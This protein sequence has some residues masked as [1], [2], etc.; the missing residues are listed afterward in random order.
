[1]TTLGGQHV[2]LAASFPSGERGQHYEP[3]DAGAIADAVTA[4]VR[5]VLANDGKMLFGGHPTITPLVLLV[6]RELRCNNAVEVFQSAWFEDQITQETRAL[7]AAGHGTIRWTARCATREESLRAMRA[8]M[9]SDAYTPAAAVFVGGMEGIEDE[10]RQVTESWPGTPR[11][12]LPGPGGAAARLPLDGA[13]S[14]LGDTVAS[15]RYPYVAAT[16]VAALSDRR[17]A[18][19]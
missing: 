19:K 4:V 10:Y 18:L 3:F 1:M 8:Q 7:A 16:M 6:A 11:I 15:R 2:F 13:S 14:L 12:P 17:Q 9:L 5:A